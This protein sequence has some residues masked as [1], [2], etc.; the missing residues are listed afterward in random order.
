MLAYTWLYMSPTH[1]FVLKFGLIPSDLTFHIPLVP[2]A[3]S[4]P[5]AD[6]LSAVPCADIFHH[7]PPP[8]HQV[9][10]DRKKLLCNVC[11]QP[12]GACIQCAGGRNCFTAFHPLCARNAGLPMVSQLVS[13]AVACVC[14]FGTQH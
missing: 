7:V 1:M 12:Y 5:A 6:L 9:S 14:L 3:S 10:K 2:Y 8:T 4:T 13:T 11:K